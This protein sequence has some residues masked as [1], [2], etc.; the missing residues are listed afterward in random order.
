[1]LE[2]VY[3]I[4]FPISTGKSFNLMLSHYRSKPVED[5]DDVDIDELWEF[6]EDI[7][8]RVQKLIKLILDS[9]RWPLVATGPVESWP[10]PT[11]NVV[12]MGD[13]AHSIVNH[14]AQGAAM[15][16]EDGVFLGRVIGKVVKS[17]LI[18]QEAVGI[19]EKTRMPRAWVK[20]QSSFT[21]GA[22]YMF[23]DGPRQRTRDDSS[24]RIVET[25]EGQDGLRG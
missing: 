8:P 19:Y 21:L 1:M 7:D 24:A 3:V 17:W 6:Y 4:T 16:M 12:L 15:S 23:E 9:K 10:S 2:K 22:V 20:Q 5:I 18:L 25:T 11:K 13:A 14:M